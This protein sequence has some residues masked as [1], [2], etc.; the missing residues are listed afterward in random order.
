MSA[1]TLTLPRRRDFDA[2]DDYDRNK[3]YDC[4]GALPGPAPALDQRWN[5]GTDIGNH[6]DE[7]AIRNASDDEWQ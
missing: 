1:T 4:P 6:A 5:G 7:R 3:H 2:D